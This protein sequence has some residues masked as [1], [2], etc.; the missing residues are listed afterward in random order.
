MAFAGI[1]LAG[2]DARRLSGVDKPMLPVGGTTLLAKALGALAG[3]RAVVVVGP[4]RTGLPELP[5]L[6]RVRERPAG[7]GPVAALAAGLAALPAVEVVV[8][9]AAD[10]TGV[11]VSTV[12]KLRG[13]L[14]S[15]GGADGAV[16]LD[17]GGHRQWLIGAWRT[18][19]LR[20]ALPADPIGASLRR[21]LGGLS[22]VEV[23]AEPGESGDVD[24]PADLDR[25][26]RAA[27]GH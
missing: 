13:A 1:V 11:S 8:A 18:E 15:A 16:L 23:G 14:A 17:G 19:S 7:S 4:E 2:G 6:T 26:R 22:L 10:L 21:T 25:A 12:D 20:A 24:T 27:R 9:L 5:A 3:A